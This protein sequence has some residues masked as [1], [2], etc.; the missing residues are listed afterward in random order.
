[1]VGG[2]ALHPA[3]NILKIQRLTNHG[4]NQPA[5][6]LG[7]RIVEFHRKDTKPENRGGA[8]TRLEKTLQVQ[9]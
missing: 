2:L 5:R 4:M 8:K 3:P 9:V 6:T 1:M 7:H